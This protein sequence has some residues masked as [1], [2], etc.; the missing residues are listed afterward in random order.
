[1]HALLRSFNSGN[2]FDSKVLVSMGLSCCAITKNRGTR[3]KLCM[4][5]LMRSWLS[6][7]LQEE[8]ADEA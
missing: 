6:L 1:M 3:T 2:W 4:C 7:V 5:V 8:S